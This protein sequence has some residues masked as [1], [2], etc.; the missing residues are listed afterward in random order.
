VNK[1]IYKFDL[2]EN[3]DLKTF[4]FSH[5]G[6]SKRLITKLKRTPNGITRNGQFIRT[7]DK[8]NYGDEISIL[9][10]D[11]NFLESNGKLAVDIVYEDE[12]FVVFN[13]PVNMPVHPS[14]KHR[15]DTLGNFFSYKFN[16]MTFRPINRLD[17][18]TSGLCVVAKNAHYANLLQGGFEKVYYAIVCGIITEKGTVKAPIMR[19]EESI[20]LRKVDENGQHAITNFTPLFNNNKYTLLKINLETGRTHQ[21]RVHMSHIGYPLAGDEMYGGNTNDIKVQALHCGEIHFKDYIDSKEKTIKSDIR[22]DMKKIL[23]LKENFL[24]RK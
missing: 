1:I 18:D 15:D 3:M 12:N 20:I 21:I 6:V 14:I 8:L 19:A 9:L 17:R 10:K 16:N 4:L 23:N 24:W 11:E 22:L 13:K 2:N 7:I 5:K